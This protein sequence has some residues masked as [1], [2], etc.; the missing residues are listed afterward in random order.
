MPDNRPLRDKLL[1][2]AS[3]S[4]S[5]VEAEIARAILAKLHPIPAGGNESRRGITRAAVL[6]SPDSSAAPLRAYRVRMP[7][8]WWALLDEDEV[9][10]GMVWSLH[11][12]HRLVV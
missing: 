12:E 4:V 9:P 5:P 6:S 3:Q 11:L 2:M 10:W 1:L 8:G 7:S